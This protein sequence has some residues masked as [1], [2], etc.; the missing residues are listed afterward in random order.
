MLQ[1]SFRVDTPE[2]VDLALEPAGLGTRF[3][4]IL[5]DALIQWGATVLL[6]LIVFPMTAVGTALNPFGNRAAL[7]GVLLT[8]LLL[9]IGFLFFLYKL[10]L[11]AFWNGQTVGKRVVGIRVIKANGLPVDFLQVVIRNLL[12]VIDYLPLQYL[13]GT[14]SI[15]ASRRG[16]R[17]GDIV[18]GTVVV[19][20]QRPTV[21]LA[22][23]QL[24]H[25]PHYDLNLLREHVLRLA[26]EDLEP[27]RR[28]WTRRMQLEN[29]SRWRVAARI[30]DSLAT[31]M[32]WQETL[33]PHPEMFIEAVLYVRAQ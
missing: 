30:V 31:R 14:V 12:R 25:Q 26:D 32:G 28:F 24:F 27:A 7:D 17:L 15:V 22:P 18:A 16:Q 29:E 10:V 33:P 9:G 3:L 1:D 5:V 8:I 4:A 2:S 13:V 6:L 11:E 19:R 23:V 20:D 21:P